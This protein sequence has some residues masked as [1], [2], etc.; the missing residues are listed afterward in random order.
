M[1]PLE[2][3]KPSQTSAVHGMHHSWNAFV[4]V[5]GRRAPISLRLINLARAIKMRRRH[6]GSRE[7]NPGETP[8]LSD[9]RKRRRP[10][11]VQ[12]GP[13]GVLL[14]QEGF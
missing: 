3:T 9:A 12:V 8:V 1:G 2:M 4:P 14:R 10:F 13:N 5:L 7:S 6:Q 11:V